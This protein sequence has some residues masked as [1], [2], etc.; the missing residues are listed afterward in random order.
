M[1]LLF[2][3]YDFVYLRPENTFSHVIISWV[4]SFLSISAPFRSLKRTLRAIRTISKN[5]LNRNKMSI[6]HQGKRC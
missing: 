5:R 1:W 2:F 3:L 4:M 6:G